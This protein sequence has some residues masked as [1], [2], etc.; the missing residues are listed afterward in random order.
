[1]GPLTDKERRVLAQ[2]N[3]RKI[4]IALLLLAAGADTKLTD[5]SGATALHMVTLAAGDERA[6]VSV[7]RELLRR[8]A[9]VDARTLDGITALQLAVG[10]KRFEVAKELAAAGADLDARDS[11]GSSAA[12]E[13]VA[14]GSQS[15]LDALRKLTAI[16]Q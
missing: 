8:R 3:A 12:D 10:N 13:L 7:T 4:R 2:R 11:H 16:R 14:Q 1:M 9:P 5:Q 15:V 6:L